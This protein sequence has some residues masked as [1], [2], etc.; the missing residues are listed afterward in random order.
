MGLESAMYISDLSA[1]NPTSTDLQ[2]QGDDHIRLIKSA[3]KN[4]F[5]NGTKP[6]YL[7]SGA[8]LQTS[9]VTVVFSDDNKLIPVSAE[10]A[11]RTVNLPAFVDIWDGFSVSIVK[12]DHSINLVTITPYGSEALNGVAGGA[13][14]LY[15]S[16]Q[17]MKCT[18]ISAISGWIAERVFIPNRGSVVPYVGTS[19]PN[20]GWL[21]ANGQAIGDASSAAAGRANADCLGLFQLLWNSFSNTVC[22]VSTGRGVSPEADFAAHKTIGLPDLRGN[23]WVGLD[24][25]GGA[26]DAGRLTANT[27]GQTNGEQIGTDSNTLARANL[28]NTSVSVTI[29][30]PGHTH[31]IST[32]YGA[33][34]GGANQVAS[35]LGSGGSNPDTDT[36][37]TNITAAFNLNGNVTQT[38]VPNLQPSFVSG[39]IIKI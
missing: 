24:N 10:A 3:V 18:Y 23:A 39:W 7:P 1:S 15:Q 5:P 28:P 36:A 31:G 29:T 26:S 22:P 11:A 16:Y 38:V 30:D 4:T 20:G 8:A 32:T 14:T 13:N 37:V 2:S 9:T 27:A 12:A 21:F 34:P 6:S 25:M 35:V 17:V 19:A 33:A